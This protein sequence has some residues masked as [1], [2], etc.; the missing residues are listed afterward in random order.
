MT[1]KIVTIEISFPVPVELP[2]GWEQLLDSAVNLVCKHYEQANPTRIMWPAGHGTK[3]LWREPQEPDMDV[4]VYAIDV[5]EREGSKKEL[6]RR[7]R[8]P[9]EKENGK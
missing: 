5:A 8:W 7:G 1:N 3:I 9:T 4:S 6:R 2:E